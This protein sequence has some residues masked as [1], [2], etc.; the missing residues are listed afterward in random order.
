MA[1][2]DDLSLRRVHAPEP[3]PS[4]PPLRPIVVAAVVLL[5]SV[6]ALKYFASRDRTPASP[7]VAQTTVHRPPVRGAGEPGEAIDLPPLDQ[8]DAVVRTLIRRLS[9]NPVI[10]RW[11]TT[12][13]LIRN[14]TVV[15]A[16]IAD[17]DTPAKHLVPLRPAGSFAARTSRGLISIDP[18]SYRRYDG[19]AAA[20]DSVDARGVAR[21]YAT[22]KPRID[23][24]Y[25]D[26]AGRDPN[27]DRTLER[28]IV[29][30]LGTPV[31]DDD[32][33]L[34]TA[35]VTYAFGDPALEDLPK[36][37]RQFLRMGPRNMRIVK[38][39][40]RAVAGFLGIPDA[41]LPAPDREPPPR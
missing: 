9:S 26:L 15:V 5:L 24:A 13:G 37:Q 7:P 2:F 23:D 38:A 11:L 21:L 22:V 29:M 31:V 3:E 6:G 32:I 28:A 10:A 30:L 14:F 25:R 12:D 18:T 34:R 27:F 39:K 4:G 17:G 16:N 41:A 1:D 35:K 20:V 33:P 8:S 36:A 19:I 40:L